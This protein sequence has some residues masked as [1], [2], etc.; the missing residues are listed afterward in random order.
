V[1]QWTDWK[2]FTREVI[3]KLPNRR[4]EYEI[5]TRN[6][7][8]IANGSSDSELTGVKGRL[9][10]RLIHNRCPTGYWFRC[11]YANWTE[12]GVQMEAKTAAR[13]KAKRGD[14]NLKNNKRSPRVRRGI[15]NI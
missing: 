15:F 13:H 1:A 5:A 3:A 7:T 14:K 4:G 10:E 6:K 2:R 8:A 9:M 11:R 12:D